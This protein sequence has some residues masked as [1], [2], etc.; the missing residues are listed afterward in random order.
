MLEPRALAETLIPFVQAISG[1]QP[2]SGQV[3][4]LAGDASARRYHR[5]V[6]PGGH[7]AA[8][9]IMELPDQPLQS[10]EATGADRP[11]E[12]PFINVHRYLARL[13]MPVPAIYR[14]DMSRGLLALEDLGDVTFEK[15][16][17]S[18]NRGRWIDCYTAALSQI[19]ALQAAADAHPDSHC[20]A[21]SRRFDKPLLRWE[22]DHFREW[23]L[24]KDRGVVLPIAEAKLLDAG[25]DWLAAVLSDSPPV[26]VHRDFQSRNLMVAP[27]GTLKI[28]DFQDALLGSRAY[29]L[30]ALLRDSY[31]V[32]A[33]EEVRTLV[34]R[35]IERAGIADAAGFHRLFRLQTLQRKLKDAGRFVFI[36]RVRKNP[37]FLRH[38]PASLL[39]VRDALPGVPELAEVAGVLRRYLP[40][41]RNEVSSPIA[42]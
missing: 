37:A 5:V 40:E 30:V 15:Q 2:N 28:I 25:F 24:E 33:P 21:F 12:L 23:L 11:R 7:P 14:V 17:V 16:L 6:I 36:D 35:F 10:D 18:L 31:V 26:F 32:L 8:V 27:D 29:D 41:L 20:L 42:I 13:G 38:I 9:I 1:G 19:V 22:L 4:T 39:Y 34:D 3:Q